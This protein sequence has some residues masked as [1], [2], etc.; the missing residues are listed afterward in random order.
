MTV[1]GHQVVKTGQQRLVDCHTF[2]GNSYLRLGWEWVKSLLYRGWRL[3][4]TL[5]LY[6]DVDPDSAIASQKQAQKSFEREFRV[7]NFLTPR[8]FVSQPGNQTVVTNQVGANSTLT[9]SYY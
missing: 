1:Q 8:S 7:R 5:F 2:R 9:T 6:R 3:F 4:S